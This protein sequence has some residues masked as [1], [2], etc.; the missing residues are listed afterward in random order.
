M[1]YATLQYAMST[2]DINGIRGKGNFR[3]TTPVAPGGSSA[4]VQGGLH[5]HEHDP[6]SA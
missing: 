4:A 6:E 5:D 2:Q 3:P 1:A